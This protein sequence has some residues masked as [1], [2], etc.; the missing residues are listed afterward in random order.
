MNTLEDR[1]DRGDS[2][3]PRRPARRGDG[4]DL[5]G[6]APGASAA[7]IRRDLAQVARAS[8]P[9]PQSSGMVPPSREAGGAWT[10]PHRP[11]AG[12]T[13]DTAACARRAVARP[14]SDPAPDGDVRG[15][16]LCQ[17]RRPPRL[18]ALHPQRL[19]RPGRS[20]GGDAARLHPVARR[21]RRRHA[22]ERS[23]R[24]AGIPCRL[25]GATAAANASK[26][27]NWFSPPISSA[28]AASP[29]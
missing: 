22:D 16:R 8:T 2:P 26:C 10:S 5:R 13:A 27:W 1:H 20:S 9:R 21:F 3:H 15:T 6:R 25:S 19:S 28:T 23:G 17:R 29:R 18:Q 24:G 14:A 11:A 4:R 7:S 12:P